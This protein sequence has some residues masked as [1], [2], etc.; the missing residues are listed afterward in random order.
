[1]K[2]NVR[3]LLVTILSLW[4]VACGGNSGGNK[5]T[6]Q[7]PPLPGEPR[8]TIL[9][10]N[11]DDSGPGSLRQA[12][13]AANASAGTDVIEFEVVGTI[14]LTA[15][16]LTI[17]DDL[18]I[19]GPGISDLTVS[20]N[21]SSRVFELADGVVTELAG[22]TI[23]DGYVFEDIAGL[24]LF[25]GGGILN[26]GDL[27]LTDVA[28]IR[29]TAY[30]D[31]NTYLLGAG[32]YSDGNLT[33]VNSIISQNWADS[34]CGGLLNV[35]TATVDG[36]SIEHNG[37]R[38]AGGICNAAGA[39]MIIR[40]STVNGNG[41]TDNDGGISNDG[42]LTLLRSTVSD[43]Q[44]QFAGGIYNNGIL[45]IDSST[46]SGNDVTN[47]GGG[48]LN[49][50]GATATIINSTI[51]GNYSDSDG[52]G[53]YNGGTLTLLDSTVTDNTAWEFGG[54]IHNIDNNLGQGSL[55]IG[56]SIVAGNHLIDD[57]DPFRGPDILGSFSSLGHNLIGNSI[58]ST[59]TP[60]AGDLIGSNASPIDPMLGPLD[61]NGGSTQTHMLLVES[62]AIDA[63]NNTLV[64]AGT[65]TDQRGF[66]RFVNSVVDM[67]SVEFGDGVFV[68]VDIKPYDELNSIDPRSKHEIPV[69]ILTTE[70]FD[71]TAVY[72]DSVRFGPSGAAKYHKHAHLEDV[73]KDGDVDLLLHFDVRHTG[74]SC[75]DSI[76]VLNGQT[77]IGQAIAGADSIRTV[78]C[79]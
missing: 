27:T 57:F 10:T 30:G 31:G 70:E 29:N 64:P 23:S 73:D 58:G 68:T 47:N 56:N 60:V 65:H 50:S 63:G 14:V 5:Q 22:M 16:K 24:N 61:D 45:N 40:D 33:L 6:Q 59:G 53:I 28:V 51:S 49:T 19:S 46:I 55:N 44:A 21:D 48:L 15:G 69:A 43:N 25:I 18:T 77:L 75:G 3:F 11:N 72:I 13:E 62:P 52:G 32:I 54:G 4:F 8:A 34:N 42:V 74:I 7:Q 71:A 79:K 66:Q 12:I 36:S 41:A 20:G 2:S 67:G 76:A 38:G 1:M 37:T 78:P 17:T 9:V 35:G 26:F 39:E